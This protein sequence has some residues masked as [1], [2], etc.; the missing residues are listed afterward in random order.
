[1]VQ[2]PLCLGDGEGERNEGEVGGDGIKQFKGPRND[3]IAL[4]K[5][6]YTAF[7]KTC[8]IRPFTSYVWQDLGDYQNFSGSKTHF[9]KGRTRDRYIQIK[10]I[11]QNGT[12]NPHKINCL[13]ASLISSS[14]HG[15]TND[16]DF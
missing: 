13:V 12:H 2:L 10:Q 8:R 5:Y 4:F 7:L 6:R 16:N 14:C 9:W 1:M 3:K 15:H 11:I